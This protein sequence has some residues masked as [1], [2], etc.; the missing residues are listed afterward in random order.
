LGLSGGVQ[1][2]PVV[3]CQLAKL[4]AAALPTACLTI[5][6]ANKLRGK[7]FNFAACE[8]RFNNNIAAA[9]AKAAEQGV[10]CRYINNGDATVSDLNTLLRW[11]KK[12][13]GNSRSID[14]QGVG[15]CLRCVGDAYPWT[16]AVSEW[17]SVL[18]GR[19]NSANAQSG[20]AGFEDWRVPTH[21]ELQTIVDCSFSS[22]VDPI[23]G[24]TAA[25]FYWSSTTNAGNPGLAWLVDF[26]F[27][28]VGSVSKNGVGHVRGVRGG[29]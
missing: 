15:N 11:E 16:T 18:N 2:D 19:S 8:T 17:L 13:A 28:A 1:A 9:D 4:K 22:C 26:G 5:Q 3:N 29:R 10:A 24:P 7:P 6:E 12:V 25:S 14:S 23:F 20:F 27:G 21:I